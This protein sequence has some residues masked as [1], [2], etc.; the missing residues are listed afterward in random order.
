MG[1]WT[2]HHLLPVTSEEWEHESRRRRRIL[3]LH[4]ILGVIGFF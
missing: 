2:P 1:G 4:F 3:I